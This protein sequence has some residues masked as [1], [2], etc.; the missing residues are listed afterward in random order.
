MY[1]IKSI[2]DKNFPPALKGHP[3]YKVLIELAK[4]EFHKIDDF[5]KMISFY[6]NIDRCPE[7]FLQHLGDIIGFTYNPNLDPI[8]QRELMKVYAQ[9]I[10]PCVGRVEDLENMATYGDVEGY[11]GGGIFVPGTNVEYPKATVIV[12]RDI[13]FT[14]S[15]SAWDTGTLFPSDIFREGVLIINVFRINEVIMNKVELVKPAG[16][17]VVY[18]LATSGGGYEYITHTKSR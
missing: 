2:L 1:N 15:A 18:Q 3:Q 10:S 4:E 8:A 11:L 13:M 6:S 7:E 16:M 14:H 12:P 17:I 9:E 5:I